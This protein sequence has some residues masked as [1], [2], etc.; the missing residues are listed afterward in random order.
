MSKRE[1]PFYT[2]AAILDRFAH[3]ADPSAHPDALEVV[4]KALKENEELRRYFFQSGPSAAWAPILWERGFFD[5]PPSPEETETGRRFHRWDVQEYLIDVAVE[6]P[7]LVV[8]FTLSIEGAGRYI[9]R[10]IQ[11][12]SH[13]PGE[14]AKSTV[15][16]ILEWLGEPRVARVI[17][18]EICELAQQLIEGGFADA[19]FTV[20]DALL[21]PVPSEDVEVVSGT[22]WGAEA[23]SRF[24]RNDYEVKELLEE[25]LPSLAEQYSEQV[26]S[27]LQQNLCSALTLEAESKDYPNFE[28]ESWW[29]TAIEDTDQDANI[30]YKGQLLRALRDCL[31]AWVAKEPSD[32][33]PL[34]AE[35]LSNERSILRRL[36][37]HILHTFP[38][39]YPTMVRNELQ[40]KENLDD[41]SLH[42]EVFLL[43]QRGF[44]VL[45]TA[46]QE[47]LVTAICNGP[48]SERRNA[49]AEWAEEK[50]VDRDQ[51]VRA[52]VSY[53]IRD[54]LLMLRNHL[55][56][57]AAE[58]LRALEAKFGPPE[59]P[60]EFTSWSSGIYWVR[61]V[62]PKPEQ[63]I[64]EMSPERL[65]EYLQE[66][67]P[68]S[69]QLYGSE[70]VSYKGLAN[71]VAKVI[72]ATP[73]RYIEHLPGIVLL[74]PEFPH[75]MLSRARE[76][77][78]TTREEWKFV[79]RL[80]EVLLE[81][82]SARTDMSRA[83]EVTWVDA[84]RSLVHVIQV[85][86]TQMEHRIPTDL[87]SKVRD[88]LFVLINDPDPDPKT[89]RP[90]EGWFGHADP[91]T[92]AINA[93]RS[94]ALLGLIE[95]AKLRAETLQGV[96][97]EAEVEGPGPS[98]L[99][100]SVRET[101]TQKLD[102]REDPSWAVHSVYGHY[103]SLL[104]WLDR[105]WVETHID[106]ILPD[107][108]TGDELRWFVAA[109]DSYVIFNNFWHPIFDLL[110]P[111]YKRAIR[112]L[113]QGRTTQ[114]HLN[115]TRRLA[116]H[117]VGQYLQTESSLDSPAETSP[118]IFLFFEHAQPQD[119]ADVPWILWKIMEANPDELEELWP[120]ARVV[121]QRRA[122]QAS[123]AGHP[124]D[125]D[126]EMQRFAHLLQVAPEY[127]TI[128]SLW[129]LLEAMLPHVTR[130]KTGGAGWRIV[131]E[132]L[133]TEV[134]RDPARV[135][136]F[137][138]LMHDQAVRAPWHYGREEP[139]EIIKKAAAKKESRDE[140]LA[141]IDLLARRGIHQFKGV[142][143]RYAG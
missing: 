39:D 117:A 77:E 89:D 99:E 134:D 104:F 128:A 63:Q 100:P 24:S 40:R 87:L 114:T 110:R 115:P 112:Y 35:Y 11:A 108:E 101:L 106:Q 61:D 92:V 6:V 141:L 82:E 130:S 123:A 67:R 66:W 29:R 131:E 80:G 137:Y 120:K 3:L 127:E 118:L 1:V 84:R 96:S 76:E 138:R 129:P 107:G 69:Q 49:F 140:A 42:H 41:T 64:G 97:E 105:E 133:A 9:S 43:L 65:T 15:P 68:D 93:V 70:R 142:Y 54:R 81:D 33:A 8:K 5:D 16:Q 7:E 119:R 45:D 94:S 122:E 62:P 88:M 113:G 103:L 47:A 26:I 30:D 32:A 53:W 90:P 126:S 38:T 116:S 143:A 78:P 102:R 111:K 50:E 83:Y 132:Y 74:R 75:A 28:K 23:K 44:P 34:I 98:R 48:P 21:E 71:E 55:S 72:L 36:G 17:A 79:I 13:I 139:R 31:E 124:T 59:F 60:P 85:G 46:D 18:G 125:F 2:Q 57:K 91:A 52:Q 58:K 136:Q 4:L 19:G 56:G 86:L 12:L 10:A 27:I 37:I 73:H 135:I 109:W 22:R 25:D 95:Y 51:Y 121:W 20:I 14:Q